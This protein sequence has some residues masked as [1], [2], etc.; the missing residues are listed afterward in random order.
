MRVAQAL[1]ATLFA[2][3][4][5]L[6]GVAMLFNAIERR[7]PIGAR[8]AETHFHT[9]GPPLA[10]DPRAERIAVETPALRHLR[11]TRGFGDTAVHRAMREVVT[12][13]WGGTSPPAGRAATALDRAEAQQ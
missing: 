12:D 6:A 13:G 9:A 2:L 4:A 10:P 7:K 1:T 5:I 8:Q 11:E 3:L